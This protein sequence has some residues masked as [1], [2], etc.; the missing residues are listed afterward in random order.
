MLPTNVPQVCHIRNAAI[1]QAIS[2]ARAPLSECLTS[3]HGSWIRKVLSQILKI[4]VILLI[5]AVVEALNELWE[6]EDDY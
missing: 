6:Q 1:Q 3:A 2:S 5:Q 4:S